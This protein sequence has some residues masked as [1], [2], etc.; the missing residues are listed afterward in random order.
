MESEGLEAKLQSVIKA[1][2]MMNRSAKIRAVADPALWGRRQILGCLVATTCVRT[3][4][5]ERLHDDPRR[6]RIVPKRV[7]EV[8]AELMRCEESEGS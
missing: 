1:E 7:G 8:K 4:W 2:A 6:P 5:R 3:E